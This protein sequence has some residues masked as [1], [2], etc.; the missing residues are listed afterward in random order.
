MP[1]QG[2]MFAQQIGNAAHVLEHRGK[3]R[4][5]GLRCLDAG[6]D[7]DGHGE[8]PC[9]EYRQR[10]LFALRQQPPKMPIDGSRWRGLEQQGQAPALVG[11]QQRV[12]RRQQTRVERGG[13]LAG[14]GRLACRGNAEQLLEIG[15]R[16]G[17]CRV[18]ARVVHGATRAG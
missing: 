17:C 4:P 14:R 8:H 9:R 5:H 7:H 6:D 13:F 18:K 10:R 12:K 3:G 11:L 1:P 16:S 15:R 2:V